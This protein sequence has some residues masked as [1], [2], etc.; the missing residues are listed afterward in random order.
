MVMEKEFLPLVLDI[1]SSS[2]NI[3]PDYDEDCDEITD[4]LHCWMGTKN[5]GR[6]KGL[7][8]LIHNEN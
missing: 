7:C 4:P 2:S 5:C 3:C 1:K 6:A 8:P